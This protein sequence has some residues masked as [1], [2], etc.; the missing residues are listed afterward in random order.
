MKSTERF[1][2]CVSDY[3]RHRPSYPTGLL[4]H[5]C[6]RGLRPGTRVADL[7]AGSGIF[8]ALLLERGAEVFAVE[9]NEAMRRAAEEQLGADR[10]FHSLPGT[11]EETGLPTASVELVTA[12]QAFHWFDRQRARLEVAR[13]LTP[14]GLV[15][16]IWNERRT[17]ADAFACAYETFLAERGVDYGQVRQRWD[18][19]RVQPVR[20]FLGGEPDVVSLP[21][22]Q[23]LDWDGLRGRALSSSYTPGEG[24]PERSRFVEE[25]G[26]LF[27]RFA[28]R[29]RVLIHYTSW[30][31]LGRLG[32]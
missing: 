12:A 5:L 17:D 18:G 29:G 6:E 24:H 26:G 27:E 30:L 20:E 15:A 23:E 14:R 25:L 8:S 32:A 11:A 3:V 16:I 28:V 9:P 31:Y 22:Q 21:S 2:D 1:T 10:R 19:L 4:D 7:G 13:I